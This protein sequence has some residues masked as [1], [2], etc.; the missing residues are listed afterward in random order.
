MARSWNTTLI[1]HF[2]CP[3]GGQVW[4]EGTTMYVGH[5]RNPYGTTIVDVAD[6]REPKVLAQIAVP[7]GW[8]SHKVRVANDVM[9]VNHE[10][11]GKGNEAFGAGLGIY[12]VADPTEP[13]LITQWRTHG[14][15]VH[16]YEFD[17]RYAYISPTAEGYVGNIMMILDLAD[18]ARPR[19]VGRWWIPG[20]WAAGG[21]DYP[22]HDFVPPRCHHPLR[23]GNRLYV[24][25]WQ[26]GGYIL[27]I[28]DMARPRP[29]AHIDTKPAFPHPTHTLLKLRQPLKGR[30]ILLVADEDVAKLRPHAPAFT[31][32]YDV[33]E[34]TKP[35]AIA[36]FQVA[37][38]DRDGSPQ[39]P[40]T[41]CHQ[42]SER[43][44]GSVIPFA[45]FAQGL[46]IVDF[47]DP[48]APKE[49]G[50]YER[51]P[52]PGA[53]R[54]SSNDVTIDS[55]GLLYVVDRVRGIDIIETNVW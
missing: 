2:D 55:R 44:S 7:E 34:E 36:T 9:I 42:P 1:G 12:D 53:D 26:H 37:G 22:W 45:W 47:T 41:G 6:P 40:M 52:A 29:I 54:A 14:A 13:K 31:W 11:F 33:T 35:A 28:T 39:P 20:Q 3:G 16:R 23:V 46:R 49:V 19:E 25:Y 4:V 50:F 48:F 51:D 27:D 32:V 24:S 38:V 15:G 43:F 17:G 8:H 18:P 10:R 21:E 5:M 30:D